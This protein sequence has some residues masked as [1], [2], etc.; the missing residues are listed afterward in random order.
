MVV[1]E[2]IFIFRTL[3]LKYLGMTYGTGFQIYSK[4]IVAI[5]MCTHRSASMGNAH[6]W[7]P[8]GSVWAFVVLFQLFYVFEY[9][10]EKKLGKILCSLHAAPRGPRGHVNDGTW[11]ERSARYVSRNTQLCISQWRRLPT[12][13]RFRWEGEVA[14]VPLPS[15]TLSPR[16]QK[17]HGEGCH[18]TPSVRICPQLSLHGMA[19]LWGVSMSCEVCGAKSVANQNQKSLHEG[20]NHIHLPHRCLPGARPGAGTKW[21]LDGMN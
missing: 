14:G 15:H 13:S 11:K 9:F 19:T 20:G 5:A 10:R 12:K 3:M 7:N 17:D 8:E 4:K 21:V 6:V 18:Q 2:N 16:T 1:E